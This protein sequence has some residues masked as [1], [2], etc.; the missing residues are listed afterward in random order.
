MSDRWIKSLKGP[1]AALPDDFRIC[2]VDAGSVGGLH[3]RWHQLRPW[4]DRIGFDPLDERADDP[5]I[6]K[7]LL[8]DREGEATL[9][10]TR[11]ETMSSTL[12]PDRNFFSPFWKK[13]D[14]VEIV[15]ELTAPMARLDDLLEGRSRQ[16]QAIKI[17]V[18][19]GEMA[20]LKGASRILRD[21]L[22]LAEVECS[23]AARY[24][25]QATIDE[26]IAHMRGHG[27]IPAAIGRIK[28]YRY[29][30][31]HGVDDASLG[32]G[33]RAGR[34]GFCDMVFLRDPESLWSRIAEG[35]DDPLA[36]IMLL[37]VYGKADIAAATFD[38]SEDQL[39]DKAREALRR[40]FKSLQG[41]GGLRQRIHWAIDQLSRGV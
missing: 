5:S 16:P 24:E 2:I 26:V 41:N 3:R 34:L 35:K 10:I 32:G 36:A 4:L 30:N 13:P 9:H 39:P 11:R 18:Q 33:I 19:G 12:R 6:Y 1:A 22:I 37:L 15:R 7:T 28:N 20:I 17:D 8:G 27:F 14:H 29:R 25:G 21:S 38:R 31:S 40:F 23:F